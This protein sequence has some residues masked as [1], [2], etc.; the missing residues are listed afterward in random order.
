MPAPVRFQPR[1]S[2]LVTLA[3]A[4]ALSMLQRPALAQFKSPEAGVDYVPVN[5]PVATESGNKVEVLDFFQY[6]CPHCYHFLPDLSAWKRRLAPDVLYRYVPVV[7]DSRTTPH[8]RIVFALEDLKRLADLHDKVF[9][10]FHVQK[11]RLLDSN[12]IAEFMQVNGIKADQWRD[13]FNSASVSA[14]VEQAAARWRAYKVEGTPA[15]GCD[16]RY[17]TAPSM[18]RSA[19]R[20]LQVMD[21][22]IARQRKLRAGK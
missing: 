22:L 6:S 21:F 17:I 1:R 18:V 9:E 19:N 4:P 20:A 2:A 7:F 14:R 5:P 10:A 8:A 11:K 15:L 16:G 3:C 12:E 13:A